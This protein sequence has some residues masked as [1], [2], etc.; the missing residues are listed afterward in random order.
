MVLRNFY[1]LISWVWNNGH[2]LGNLDTLLYDVG[3]SINCLRLFQDLIIRLKT[4]LL[5]NIWLLILTNIS[6]A[7]YLFWIDLLILIAL[8]QIKILESTS[9]W[10]LHF[11][12]IE[13]FCT[14][15]VS[16]FQVIIFM[17]SLSLASLFELIAPSVSFF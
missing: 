5:V 17:I 13:T 4:C 11:L 9:F 15:Q 3:M 10:G 8:L 14:V 16:L 6:L 12:G 2:I 7:S 1:H